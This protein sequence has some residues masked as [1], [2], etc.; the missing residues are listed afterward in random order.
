M[1]VSK[2]YHSESLEIDQRACKKL[3]TIYLAQ[4]VDTQTRGGSRACTHSSAL[5]KNLPVGSAVSWY[6]PS[7]PL[8]GGDR[9]G[10]NYS[11]WI[12]YPRKSENP[13]I[14]QFLLYYIIQL[15]SYYIIQFLLYSSVLWR[16]NTKQVVAAAGQCPHLPPTTK[17]GHVLGSGGEISHVFLHCSKDCSGGELRSQ[18]QLTSLLAF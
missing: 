5:Q 3:R 15:Y 7:H 9:Q 2:N 12:Q 18:W 4:S 1:K 11:Y 14:I 16:A 10:R 8:C 6:F 13:L 17:V